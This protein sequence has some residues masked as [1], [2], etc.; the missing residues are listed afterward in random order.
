MLTNRLFEKMKSIVVYGSPWKLGVLYFF[1]DLF[2][3]KVTE[4]L[5][6]A[7]L[8]IFSVGN[9][10]CRT[11]LAHGKNEKEANQN[12]FEK[13]LSRERKIITV[14][15]RE[16]NPITTFSLTELSAPNFF[17]ESIFSTTWNIF[18][19]ARSSRNSYHSLSA[20]N[21]A[22]SKLDKALSSCREAP[23]TPIF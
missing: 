21:F 7:E 12:T 18:F 16:Q 2:P 17:A 13:K 11:K 1:E 6:E 14:P 9:V 23:L 4:K 19:L 3:Y 5:L 20:R 15:F 10:T 22:N 8:S